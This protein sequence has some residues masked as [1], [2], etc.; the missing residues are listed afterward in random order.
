MLRKSWVNSIGT[1]SSSIEESSS[2]E[3][4]LLE[5]SVSILVG[6]LQ[7]PSSEEGAMRSLGLR[8]FFLSFRYKY[9]PLQTTNHL[10]MLA[11]Y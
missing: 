11:E 2:P 8:F 3:Y 5:S 1:V 4:E 7:L 9:E 6:L 10:E